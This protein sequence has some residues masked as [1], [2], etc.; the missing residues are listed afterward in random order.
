M[1]PA[2]RQIFTRPHTFL[3]A[4]TLHAGACCEFST[5]HDDSPSTLHTHTSRAP[6]FAHLRW[7]QHAQEAL[8]AVLAASQGKHGKGRSGKG[9][10]N[11]VFGGAPV[12]PEAVQLGPHKDDFLVQMCGLTCRDNKY[13]LQ[14]A[15]GDATASA[16]FTPTSTPALGPTTSDAN[17][18]A[19]AVAARGGRGGENG[20]GKGRLIGFLSKHQ[21]ARPV[22]QAL[23]LSG[24]GQVWPL[25][26][27]ERVYAWEQGKAF[28]GV[29]LVVLSSS[30][31]SPRV[32]LHFSRSP[33]RL[34]LPPRMPTC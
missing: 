15:P 20:N 13:F 17:G 33:S 32:A 19:A 25:F 3:E 29:L 8:G 22:F 1:P 6:T 2:A 11:S 16:T 9:S 24:T 30:S 23:K 27:S 34:T 28:F 4:C 12:P 7:L 26:Q 14:D 31:L 10:G 5:A 18:A 21:E